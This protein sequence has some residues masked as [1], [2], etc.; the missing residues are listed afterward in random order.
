M[1]GQ[2]GQNLTWQFKLKLMVQCKGWVNLDNQVTEWTAG[3]NRVQNLLCSL[4]KVQV[5]LRAA[6]ANSTNKP[7]MTP[8]VSAMYGRYSIGYEK[9]DPEMCEVVD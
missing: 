2:G 6:D 7:G 4:L 1:E 8:V 9:K 3:T 5:S